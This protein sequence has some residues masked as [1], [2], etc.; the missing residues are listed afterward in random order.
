M[1]IQPILGKFWAIFGLYQPSGPPFWI[2]ASPFYISWIRPWLNI[3]KYEVE[4]THWGYSSLI[5][6]RT[7]CWKLESGPIPIPPPKKKVTHPYQLAQFGAKFWQNN[8][9]FLKFEKFLK[10]LPIHIRYQILHFIKA[11]SL[12]INQEAYFATHVCS[13]TGTFVLSSP[14]P[15]TECRIERLLV[16]YLQG[17]A[18]NV[19]SGVKQVS[20]DF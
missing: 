7:C 19:K 4:C 1:Q 11:G 9:I 5:L 12:M 20:S 2:S 10:N 6:V 16:S 18:F 14:H 8:L 13:T 15:D 3:P 17:Q